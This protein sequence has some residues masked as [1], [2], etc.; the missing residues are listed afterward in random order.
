MTEAQVLALIN[1]FIIANGNNEITADVLRP[2]LVA[3]LEQP[4]DKVGELG[5]LQTTDQ[6]NIVDAINELV[7]NSNNN[8]E[9]H[10]G[11]DDPNSNPPAS[12][13]IGDW[14]IRDGSSLYQY[15][16][17]TWVLLNDNSVLPRDMAIDTFT[18]TPPNNTFTTSDNIYQ[19][20]DVQI[21]QGC[22]YDSYA[23]INNGNEVAISTDVLYGGE[24]IKIIYTK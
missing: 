8:F 6:S 18:Y 13:S 10:S 22:N 15:N 24:K 5:D 3:I 23:I 2:I 1:Q 17:S 21:N 9:I 14:Y 4:N 16:G 11:V 19:L 20:F 12:F 7:N